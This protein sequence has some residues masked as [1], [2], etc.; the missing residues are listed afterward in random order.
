T[1]T[2]GLS[3]VRSPS[4][5]PDMTTVATGQFPPAGLSPTGSTTSV[6]APRRPCFTTPYSSAFPL[7]AFSACT[8]SPA[9]PYKNCH[10]SPTDDGRWDVPPLSTLTKKNTA[11]RR[12]VSIS[13]L[14][15]LFGTSLDRLLC[16]ELGS[17]S[18]K[19]LLGELLLCFFE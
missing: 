15:S 18:G 3:T 4:P 9:C 1:F 12:T 19:T 13:M 16:L 14:F 2:S 10:P 11:V 5:L 6:A 17:L 8:T 7:T